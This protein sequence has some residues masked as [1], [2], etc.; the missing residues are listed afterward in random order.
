MNTNKLSLFDRHV[1]GKMSQGQIVKKVY[2][3]IKEHAILCGPSR[4]DGMTMLDMLIDVEKA[5]L[6]KDAAPKIIDDVAHNIARIEQLKNSTCP[7]LSVYPFM[8]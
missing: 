1:R 8:S 7:K 4:D 5:F 6:H 3:Y 2:T